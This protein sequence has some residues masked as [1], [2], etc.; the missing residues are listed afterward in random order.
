MQVEES[1]KGTVLVV[2]AR[3]RLDARS[4]GG[5]QGRLAAAIHG[6]ETRILLDFSDLAD[7]SSGGLRSLLVA[8]KRLQGSNGQLAVCGLTEN[9]AAVFRDSG[10]D[11]I[12]RTFPDE[13]AALGKLHP[14]Q[15]WD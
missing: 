8:A 5:F 9:V 6:G 14:S 12:I 7:T 11:A 13:G 10:F 1:K 2:A 4:A 3:G 15:T